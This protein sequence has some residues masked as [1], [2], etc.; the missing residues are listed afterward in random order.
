MYSPTFWDW[1]TFFGSIGLFLSLLFLFVRFLPMISIAEMRALL[2]EVAQPANTG[3][4]EGT[5]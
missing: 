2:P 4:S 1:A 5:T 3:R